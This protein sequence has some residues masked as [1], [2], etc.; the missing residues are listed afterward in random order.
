MH[1]YATDVC[2]ECDAIWFDRQGVAQVGERLMLVSL[3]KLG[4]PLEPRGLNVAMNQTLRAVIQ[5]GRS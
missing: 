3:T 1:L 2:E 5:T 4:G